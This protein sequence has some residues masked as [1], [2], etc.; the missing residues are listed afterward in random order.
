MAEGA[1]VL[2][3]FTLLFLFLYKKK[4]HVN[5]SY[6]IWSL[7]VNFEHK[8]TVNQKNEKDI[9]NFHQKRSFEKSKLQAATLTS[10]LFVS[11]SRTDS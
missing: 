10:L 5:L 4:F 9:L 11:V 1:N 7:G 6:V 3:C 2:L 8:K